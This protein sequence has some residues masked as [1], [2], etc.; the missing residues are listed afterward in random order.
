MKNVML[1]IIA[2]ITILLLTSCATTHL[3][4]NSGTLVP[5]VYSNL[6]ADITVGEKISGEGS[7][8]YLLGFLPLTFKKYET[9][10]IL[11]SGAVTTVSLNPIT[12][13]TD[14]LP[15]TNLAK[16]QAAYN[17]VKNSGA[18]VIVDPVFEM[19]TT[20][21]ILFKK[22]TCIVTGYKGTIN[23]IDQVKSKDL[24]K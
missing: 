10:G 2:C 16:G 19:V 14:M 3:G 24:I 18:D 12:M 22:Q 17:A 11:S 15:E 5:N 21:F 8:M 13:I 23:S 1:K 9:T 6:E 7:A 4:D 20:N